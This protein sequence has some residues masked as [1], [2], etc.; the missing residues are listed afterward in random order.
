LHNGIFDFYQFSILVYVDKRSDRS[1]TMALFLES[2]KPFCAYFV[3]YLLC[4][5][6]ALLAIMVCMPKTVRVF[7]DVIRKE[8]ETR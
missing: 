3:L 2:V 4:P 6:I 1:I 8:G 5:T 7:L